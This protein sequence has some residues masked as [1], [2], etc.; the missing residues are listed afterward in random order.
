MCHF[1]IKCSSDFTCDLIYCALC[2]LLHSHLI[3]SIFGKLQDSFGNITL[4]GDFSHPVFLVF[5][6]SKVHHNDGDKSSMRPCSYKEID[7]VTE[8]YSVK[9]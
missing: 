9:H 5:P 1:A 8:L 7:Y 4:L 6:D 2:I 3:L